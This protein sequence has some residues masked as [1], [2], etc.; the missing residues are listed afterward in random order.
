MHQQTPACS[1]LPGIAGNMLT[2]LHV[3]GLLLLHLTLSCIHARKLL[4]CLTLLSSTSVV[5]Q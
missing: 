2:S 4:G 5:Q 1:L 3:S